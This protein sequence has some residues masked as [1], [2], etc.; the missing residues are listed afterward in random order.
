MPNPLDC[1]SFSLFSNLPSVVGTCRAVKSHC[2]NCH[3]KSLL[4]ELLGH[5]I[6][7]E[8]SSCICYRPLWYQ[9]VFKE[10]IFFTILLNF[11]L[12]IFP[13]L[14]PRQRTQYCDLICKLSSRVEEH[15]P[16]CRHLW[17]SQIRKSR[18]E[19]FPLKLVKTHEQLLKH[20]FLLKTLKRQEQLSSSFRQAY[21]LSCFPK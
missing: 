13:T 11:P 20:L 6:V 10:I 2:D 9:N 8:T 15:C 7:H 5:K 3:L 12:N 14:V 1:I 18:G 19:T 21:R 17:M 16:F 4:A